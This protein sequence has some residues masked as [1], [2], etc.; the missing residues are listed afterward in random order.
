MRN[1]MEL[2]RLSWA[3]KGDHRTCPL[4]LASSRLSIVLR[5]AN[6]LDLLRADVTHHGVGHRDADIVGWNAPAV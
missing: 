6:A 5:V 2:S 3:L 4:V 1:G